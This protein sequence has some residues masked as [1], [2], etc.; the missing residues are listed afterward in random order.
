MTNYG[1]PVFLANTLPRVKDSSE[2]Y[3]RRLILV[4]FNQ[5]IP[6]AE[7]DEGLKRKIIATEMPGVFN[8]VLAGLRRVWANKDFTKA[9]AVEDAV[10]EYR[11]K[12]DTVLGFINEN[13]VEPCPDNPRP[14][15][16]WYA[17]YLQYCTEVGHRHT[18]TRNQFS[19]R[20]RKHGITVVRSKAGGNTT[21]STVVF[22][23]CGTIIGDNNPF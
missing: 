2:G 5:T 17:Q 3:F 16:G 22:A 23:R 6:H 11:E 19:D 13:A 9:K 12:S 8:W 10:A 20:L 15:K 14:L 1:K 21:G 18:V 4:P 7:R